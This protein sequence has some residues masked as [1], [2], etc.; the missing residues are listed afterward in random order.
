MKIIHLSY[1]DLI[2]GADRAAY[3]IHLSLLKEGIYSRMW[4]NQT[5]AGDDTVE[6]PNNKLE[7]LSNKLRLFIS[8]H[9][10]NRFFN[11]K[12][13][14]LNSYS[15]LKSKL[16]KKI[17]NSDADIV[18]LHWIQNEMLSIKD[19]SQIKKPIIWTFHD[20]WPFCGAEHYTDNHRWREGYHISNK[21]KNESKLD[22]NLWTWK[23]K[24]KYWNSPIQIITPSKWLANCA[25][26][27]SLMYNWP[28]S[29]IAYPINTDFWRPVDRKISRDK[30]NLSHKPFLILFGGD[31]N[32]PRK[33]FDLLIKVLKN[34]K[35]YL[36]A[37]KI[38]LVIF[39]CNDQKLFSDLGFTIHYTSH[40]KDSLTLKALYSAADV[41]IFP[42][43]QDNLPNTVIEAQVCGTPVVAFNIGGLSDIIEHKK[44]GYLAEAF[45][46]ED[47]A[48][49]I[50]WVVNHIE[51]R[52][53]RKNTREKAV[54]KFNEKKIAQNYL[55][56]YKSLL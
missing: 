51:I 15:I 35:L 7:I 2:G 47:L 13:N 38:E 40:I 26:I 44:T 39:G 49:G 12:K 43:R 5:L 29:R 53:L 45:N 48:N 33:G 11:T 36:N 4:V 16:V 10:L 20:M 17:N 9:V 42:S 23:R 25:R 56:V 3:R 30:L 31:I 46:I 8:H 24:K 34:K 50:L 54:L 22:L 1:S 18:H 55:N 14:T 52:K 21:P 41:L 32:D 28:V 6:G 37:E 19:I 27:S